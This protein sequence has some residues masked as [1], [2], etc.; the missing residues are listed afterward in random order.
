VTNDGQFF[1]LKFTRHRG[2]TPAVL[3]FTVHSCENP[4]GTQI[5]LDY[6]LP[7]FDLLHKQKQIITFTFFR[8]SI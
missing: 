8:S 4:T 5:A 6:K 7:A 1:N 3:Y 2:F